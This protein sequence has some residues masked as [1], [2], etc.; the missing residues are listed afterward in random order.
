[1]SSTPGAAESGRSP[2][3]PGSST[4]GGTPNSSW[5]GSQA[6]TPGVVPPS[7]PGAP[8]GSEALVPVEQTGPLGGA[9]EEGML[10]GGCRQPCSLEDS[11]PRSARSQ[12]R[13]HTVCSNAYKVLQRRWAKEPALKRDWQ[14]KSEED[15]TEWYRSRYAV[16]RGTRGQKRDFQV[17][18]EAVD[19]V[20]VF[21]DAAREVLYEPYSAFE[22][23]FV[24][25]GKDTKWIENHWRERLAD[26]TNPRK[27]DPKTGAT[28]LGKYLGPA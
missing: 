21:L 13:Y 28:L 2:A 17:T 9:L 19:E 22:E 12:V 16:G 1:M 18:Q 3:T 4:P 5:F 11:K 7:T 6:A 26:G 20:G 27:K 10:C 23:R 25:M 14:E 8:P 24:L 15:I